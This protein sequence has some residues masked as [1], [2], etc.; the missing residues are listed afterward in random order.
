MLLESA[1]RHPGDFAALAAAFGKGEDGGG[2]GGGGGGYRV[3]VVFMA[4]PA[5]LS[6]LGILTRFFEGKMEGTGRLGVRL[7]P[8]RTHDES[9]EA[10]L[11]AGRWVDDGGGGGEGLVDQVVVLRR[12]NMVAFGAERERNVEGRE[13]DGTGVRGGFGG[14][15]V[16]AV[17]RERRRRLTN[18]EKDAA[19]A[20]LQ[21]LEGVE[22]AREVLAEVKGLLEPLMDGGKD[23]DEFPELR[24]LLFPGDGGNGG[25]NVLKL[26]IA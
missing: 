24:P 15:V 13:G 9:F 25:N 2:G 4:V 20:D 12:G 18:D 16:E 14:R 22:D 23:G 6:R 10:V 17:E 21:R 7:T 11:E 5:G 1:C 19:I 26:G 8:R 3:E